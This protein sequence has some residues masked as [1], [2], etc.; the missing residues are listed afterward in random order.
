MYYTEWLNEKITH[1]YSEEKFVFVVYGKEEF[2]RRVNKYLE[3]TEADWYVIICYEIFDVQNPKVIISEHDYY[4]N[5]TGVV[6]K[7]RLK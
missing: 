6:R 5:T 4:I 3:L 7:E 2:V 1:N